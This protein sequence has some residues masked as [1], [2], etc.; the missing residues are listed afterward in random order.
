MKAIIKKSKS[1]IKSIDKAFDI[2]DIVS[3]VKDGLSLTEIA[4]IM[5]ISISSA[6]HLLSTLVNNGYIK[7]NVSSKKYRLGLKTIIIGNKYLKNL[8][9]SS[10]ALPYLKEIQDTI[11]ETVYLAKIENINL[12]IIEIFNSTHNIRPFDV[13]VTKNEYHASALGKILLCSLDEINLNNFLSKRR[14]KKFTNNTIT[15][16]DMLR[17]ELEKIKKSRV[18]FDH[19]ELEYGLCCI[20]SPILNSKSNIIGSIGISIPKQRFS[21]KREKEITEFLKSVTLEISKELGYTA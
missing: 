16:F 8:S 2:L 5:E 19:E 1:K 9:L 18:A 11:N 17:N 20:A 12:A 14:L 3:D 15:K 7:Q 10:I 21:L 6:H 13:T 4:K